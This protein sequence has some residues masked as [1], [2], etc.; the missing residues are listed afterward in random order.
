MTVAAH[1]RPVPG[2]GASPSEIDVLINEAGKRGFVWHLFRT[3]QHGPEILAGVLRWPTCSDVV[4]LIDDH[5]SHAY[6]V[7]TG[8]P[9]IRGVRPR[10]GPLVLRAERRRGDDMGPACITDT[11]PPRRA[12][13]AAHTGSRARRDR[14]SWRPVTRRDSSAVKTGHASHDAIRYSSNEGNK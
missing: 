14:R 6:R 12:S 13:R 1:S 2:A 11:A 10:A 4:V 9:V 7:P 3:N 5:R 8:D